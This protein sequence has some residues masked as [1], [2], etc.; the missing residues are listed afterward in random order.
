M[1]ADHWV[2]VL[3]NKDYIWNG[4]IYP[5]FGWLRIKCPLCF[6]G[7]WKTENVLRACD[8]SGGKWPLALVGRGSS[9]LLLGFLWNIFQQLACIPAQ[10][11]YVLA[12][13]LFDEQQ[14][15][16]HNHV[17]LAQKP[18]TATWELGL[19]PSLVTQVWSKQDSPYFKV[20]LLLI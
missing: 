2:V 18:V 16:K 7:N 3:V 10:Y 15:D 19:N 5:S 6:S 11:P 13:L 8:C 12:Q 14:L 1:T 4:W 17:R 9:T 20:K